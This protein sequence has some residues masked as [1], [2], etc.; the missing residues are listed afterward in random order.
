MGLRWPLTALWK[1]AGCIAD[2]KGSS[3]DPAGLK[4]GSTPPSHCDR[5]LG[6]VTQPLCVLQ[7][8]SG[9]GDQVCK[10]VGSGPASVGTRPPPWPS[11]H[12]CACGELIRL[13]DRLAGGSE[14]PGACSGGQEL[15]QTVWAW[16]EPP[17][18]LIPGR[19]R[20]PRSGTRT[21]GGGTETSGVGRGPQNGDRDTG[22]GT[23]TP[24]EGQRPKGRDRDPGGIPRIV[25]RTRWWVGD[26][27]RRCAMGLS[28]S[29]RGRGESGA[30]PGQARQQS[31][32]GNESVTVQTRT[33]LEKDEGHG[34]S[35]QLPVV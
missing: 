34:Q 4:F 21:L 5:D 10:A 2:K 15:I 35:C 14:T 17:N 20:D 19:D 9:R 6:P 7:E 25:T 26:R 12:R 30:G 11:H 33:L 24:G 32:L 1:W 23:E 18:P 31:K 13:H 16:R 3:G 22:G 27:S 8:G 28:R 29:R